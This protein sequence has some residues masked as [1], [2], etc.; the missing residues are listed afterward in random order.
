MFVCSSIFQC[1]LIKEKVENVDLTREALKLRLASYCIL[2]CPAALQSIVPKFEQICST[3]PVQRVI[4]LTMQV[5]QRS[6]LDDWKNARVVSST[7][8][9]F[10]KFLPDATQTLPIFLSSCLQFRQQRTKDELGLTWGKCSSWTCL[11]NCPAGQ[12]R[13]G[14]GSK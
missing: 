11:E 9:R 5:A 10:S 3:K 13:S 1:H 14:Y 12:D 2:P 6:D 4:E 8:A 7:S